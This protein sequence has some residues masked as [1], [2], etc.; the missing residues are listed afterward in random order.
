[1]KIRALIYLIPAFLF[2]AFMPSDPDDKIFSTDEI[3]WAGIDFSEAKL[4]GSEGFTNPYDVKNRFF[5]SW[6]NLILTESDKYNIKEFYKKDK[7]I[8]DLSVVNERNEMPD[9]DDLVINESYSFEN[10]TVESI[11]KAY[12]LEKKEEGVGLV[13][14]VESFDKTGVMATINVV[15][16]DIGSKKVLWKEQYHEKPGGFGLRNYWAGAILKV[17]KRSKE[18][19]EMARLNN[20]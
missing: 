7:V 18:D 17:M 1:M 20:K 11:V 6:N 8:N 14:I 15:F 5:N 9:P 13:Y 4:I 16:F 3:V 2:M 12:D 10:G 19:Y